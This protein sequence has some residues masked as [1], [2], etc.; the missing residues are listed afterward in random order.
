MSL[1]KIIPVKSHVALHVKH[2]S[3]M[4]SP[5]GHVLTI[6]ALEGVPRK[7]LNSE[8]SHFSFKFDFQSENELLF[9]NL[10][11]E[12][13]FNEELLELCSDCVIWN[14]ASHLC[15][16]KWILTGFFV[17]IKMK[18]ERERGKKR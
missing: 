15:S 10:N 16:Q 9:F 4:F 2:D 11:L 6:Y 7:E 18:R 14:W 12:K 13:K 1:L 17:A 5:S 3:K 8:R